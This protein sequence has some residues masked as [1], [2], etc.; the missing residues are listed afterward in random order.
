MT[1]MVVRALAAAALLAGAA[2][3]AEVTVDRAA[4]FQTILGWGG[5]GWGAAMPADLREQILDELVGE[6]GL[7]GLRLE[8]PSGNR[9]WLRR[10]EWSNDDGD[11]FHIHW[12]AFATDAFDTKVSQWVVP[13]EKRVVGRGEP[14]RLYVSPSF[15]NGGSSGMVPAWMLHNPQEYAENALA[16]LLRLR[17]AHGIAATHY[18]ICNEAGNNNLFSAKVL[19]EAIKA[20]GPRM[21]AAGLP[22]TVQFPECVNADRSWQYIQAVRDDPDVWKYVGLLSYHLYGPKTRRPDIRDFARARRLP[23]AQ[24]EFMGTRVDDLYEDL[25]EGGVSYWEHYVLAGLG[26]R[27]GPGCYVAANRNMTSFSR[28]REYWKFRQVM[29]YVRPGAVRVGAASDDPAV[30]ALAFEREGKV[31]VVLLNTARDA[32]PQKV[33]VP[34]LPAG[35]YGVSRAV[36]NRPYQE[37]GTRTVAA[38]GRAEV[39][40]PPVATRRDWSLD[41]PAGAVLTIYPHPGGNLPP[42]P[43]EWGTR[44]AYLT[45]PASRAT[46]WAAA[47]D[48]EA[49]KLS[50]SWSV[51]SQPAGARAALASPGSAV[52]EAT[53]L[54]RP[55][56]YTFTVTVSDGAASARR[57]VMLNVFAGNQP[58]VIVD[59]HNRIPVVVTLPESQTLLRGGAWDVEGDRLTLRWSVLRRPPG[60]KVVLQ[61]PDKGGGRKAVGMTAPGEYVFGLQ[62]DDGTNT[63]RDELKVTVY[64]PNRPPVIARAAAKITGAQAAALSAATSDPDGDV[65]S[66]CWSVKRAPDGAAP[67]FARPGAAETQ[68]TGLTKAGRYVFTLTVVDRSAFTRQDVTLAVGP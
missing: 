4:R 5:T 48:A 64:P 58:P 17:D 23:T 37:L 47:T 26:D 60:A 30:R 56:R 12:P 62:A 50:W 49:G 33:A 3:A 13:F 31:T 46:L 7:T 2:G 1:R 9:S 51:K 45:A 40:R 68:V 27:A 57:D 42:T 32:R 67:V 19:A 18:S 55:G 61:E 16:V 21:K 36:G 25:T 39:E 44:P 35:T 53:G 28:Y 24:T 34:K 6:L 43:T 22:T 8:L 11:P 14:F 63:V 54:V 15:F 20:L 59:L 41:L 66:H 10:W 52:T 65:I 38:A 29:H